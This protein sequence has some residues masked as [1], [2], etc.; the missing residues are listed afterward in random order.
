MKV[1]AAG[2][3]LFACSSC[4]TLE[5]RRDLYSSDPEIYWHPRSRTVRETTTTTRTVAPIPAI[6]DQEDA[7][8]PGR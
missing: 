3:I 8:P 6:P 5:N 2:L 1:L 7:A 4:M